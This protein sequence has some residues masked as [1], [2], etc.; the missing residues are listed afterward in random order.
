MR[1]LTGKGLWLQRI[2]ADEAPAIDRLAARLQAAGLNHLILKI[3]DGADPDPAPAIV[4]LTEQLSA[5]GVDVW[6]WH[7]L[8][9]DQPGFKGAYRPDY[10][11]REAAA[12]LAQ[13]ARLQPAGLRGLVLEAR[14]EYEQAPARGQRAADYLAALP[15]DLPL[16]LS[17]WKS[18]AAHPRFPWAE[19]RARCNQDLPPVFWVGQHGEGA[20][21]LQ[22]VAR[23][24]RAL[25]PTRP[26][27]VAGPAFFESD[28]RPALPD[29]REFLQAAAALELAGVNL[30]L[31][32][33]LRWT[34]AEP[35]ALNPRQFDFRPHWEVFSAFTWPGTAPAAPPP[36]TVAPAPPAEDSAPESDAASDLASE[37]AALL[38]DADDSEM[39]A[40]WL[41]GLPAENAPAEDSA[42]APEPEAASD[43]ASEWAALLADADDSTMEAAWLAGLPAESTPA[44]DSAPEADAASDLAS[45]WAALLADTDD[46]EIEAAWLAGLPAESAPAEV[47]AAVLEEA[48]TPDLEAVLDFS[49]AA[50]LAPIPPLSRRVF[51][52]AGPAPAPFLPPTVSRFF[53]ALR[54]RRV[55]E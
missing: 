8:Y 13:L 51:M 40:A 55:D 17:S 10:H 22:A 6:G 43:L 5:A 7:S 18:P 37:W 39:E 31:W 27:A 15:A 53:K 50:A 25:T 45:E 4:A 35:A 46:S 24:Y 16:A 30:W 2:S 21:Q 20:R 38:A 33:Q 41:A 1:L 11:Q 3:A 12:S 32:D 28:W 47:P 49:P 23:Q 29:L 9:G 14:A 48:E 42:L 19:F 54:Q 44:E 52:S 26:L 34:G 36:Q